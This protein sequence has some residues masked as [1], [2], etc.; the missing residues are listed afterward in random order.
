MFED[1]E[2]P[3]M[4][5][6]ASTRRTRSPV[7]HQLDE[8]V[9]SFN[10]QVMECF[11][12]ATHKSRVAVNPEYPPPTTIT[13]HGPEADVRFEGGDMTPMEGTPCTSP[14]SGVH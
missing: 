13:S 14:S 9:R 4:R 1:H 6:R 2:R 11:I 5:S 3:P 8:Q 7:F 10:N 12:P